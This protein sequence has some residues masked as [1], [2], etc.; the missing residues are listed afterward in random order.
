MKFSR[1]LVLAFLSFIVVALVVLSGA[2]IGEISIPLTTFIKTLANYCFGAHY[3]V[4]TIDQKI[5]WELRLPRSI[6]AATTGASLA[7]CGVVLQS[8]LRNALAEPYLLGISSGAATGAVLVTIVGVGGGLFSISTGALIG[9]LLAF[10][11]VVFISYHS[12]RDNMAIILAGIAAGQLFTA[13]TALLMWI[14]GDSEV[15]G[16]ILD[17]LLG[18]LSRARWEDV[19]YAIPVL[20]VSL[21]GFLSFARILDAFVFGTRSAESLGISLKYVTF[22]LI[23][24]VAII[25]AV[26]VSIVGTVGFVGLVIPHAARFIVGQRH[27]QLL[28][29]TAFI[30]AIFMVC[31]DIVSRILIHGFAIPIGIVTALI[32]APCFVFLLVKRK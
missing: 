4:D 28:P 21:I 3:L 6:I 1:K 24:L 31:A 18:N 17:W 8:I 7:L 2:A 11:T 15:R 20:L 26:N 12:G 23:T 27:T 14:Y 13:L 9:G 30:G 5:I 10:A 29:L 32:G 19:L 25:T 22:F 16:R